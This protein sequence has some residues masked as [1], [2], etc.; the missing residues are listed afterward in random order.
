MYGCP[1]SQIENHLCSCPP[2]FLLCQFKVMAIKFGKWGA[3]L[4]GH[5]ARYGNVSSSLDTR[6][7][8][9]HKIGLH[10]AL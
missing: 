3:N 10:E 8:S 4:L 5:P 9:D 1:V 6:F 2:C 7:M